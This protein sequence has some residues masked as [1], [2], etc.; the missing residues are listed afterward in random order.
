[1]TLP[2]HR[3]RLPAAVLLAALAACDGG[4]GFDS[5]P[6][7][8]QQVAA[9]YQVCSL[10]F[11]PT[12]TALPVADLLQGV[13]QRTPPAGKPLPTLTLSPSSAQY[14][15]VY[16]RK[17]DNF[18]QQLRGTV[19]YGDNSVFLNVGAASAI[20]PQELLLPP[21]HLD[22]VF[23]TAPK[24]LS[25]GVEVSQ[26]SVRREDYARAAGITEEGLAQRIFGH[27]SAGFAEGDCP[28]G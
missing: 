27:L 28:A 15:L 18:L 21:S 10:K 23:S 5:D 25:A 11:T 8:P 6:L 14:E 19:E 2:G 26:Y 24:R 20:V 13:V 22:L 9:V 16:T 3:F 12:Q 17:S 4:S 1:M 7:T